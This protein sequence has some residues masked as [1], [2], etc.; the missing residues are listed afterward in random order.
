MGTSTVA[1]EEK[2]IMATSSVVLSKSATNVGP[3]DCSAA[4][5]P[6]GAMEPERSTTMDTIALPRADRAAPIQPVKDANNATISKARKN[7]ELM[8]DMA[9]PF[10]QGMGRV[11]N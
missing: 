1:L 10:V 2:L 7:L 5:P 8:E 6:S 9:A 4:A 3:A 11:Y